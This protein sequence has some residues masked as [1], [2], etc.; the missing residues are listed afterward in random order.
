[1]SAPLNTGELAE[2]SDGLT[3]LLWCIEKRNG[4][5][6]RA[7]L[8]LGTIVILKVLK[9]QL[10][11]SPFLP[12][13]LGPK[14]TTVAVGILGALFAY[15]LIAQAHYA[16]KIEKLK[17]LG[18][19]KVTLALAGDVIKKPRGWEAVPFWLGAASGAAVL[20]VVAMFAME[21]TF[22]LIFDAILGIAR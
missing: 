1:M 4:H 13:K 19:T 2:P 14:D 21:D 7:L 12:F 17:A 3:A 10:S 8:L 5:I 20:F 16:Q 15:S 6:V 18:V 22:V 11:Y 9:V